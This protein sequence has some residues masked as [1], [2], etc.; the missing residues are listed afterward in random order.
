MVAAVFGVV[1]LA[2]EEAQAQVS[3]GAQASYADDMDFGIGAR[4][5]AGLPFTGVEFMGS[6]DYFFP[7]VDDFNYFEVNANAL[8]SLPVANM[9]AFRPYVG[10]GLNFA[11][12]SMDIPAELKPFIEGSASDTELGLNLI[13]GAEFGVGRFKPFA[14]LRAQISGGEQVV[15]AAGIRM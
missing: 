5:Y 10:G 11:R 3:F 9:P 1:I 6:F 7:S 14:E 12:W 13:G 4:V 15:L 8:Y 2:A